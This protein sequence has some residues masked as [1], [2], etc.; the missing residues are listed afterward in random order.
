MGVFYICQCECGNI[1][2]YRLNSIKFGHIKSCGCSK[3][4]N[5]LIIEDLTGQ[6]FGRLTVVGRDMERD[7]KEF[8]QGKRRGNVHWLCRC[9]CGNERLSSVVGWQ[10]KSGKTKSCGC[11]LSEI[12]AERNRR[13]STKINRVFRNKENFK[14]YIENSIVRVYGDNNDGSFYCRCR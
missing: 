1:N 10:L 9:D 13:D 2:T 12:T 4:N 8:K 14:D 11:I 6:K 3:F 5:P 7:G